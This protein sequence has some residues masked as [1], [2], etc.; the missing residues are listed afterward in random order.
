MDVSIFCFARACILSS[1]T[2][3]SLTWQAAMQTFGTKLS[4]YIRRRFK[5]PQDWFGTLTWLP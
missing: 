3:F 1:N 4:V 5:L 2:A